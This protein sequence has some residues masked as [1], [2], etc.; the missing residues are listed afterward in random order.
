M[1]RFQWAQL[2]ALVINIVFLIMCLVRG[3]F[4]AFTCLS[5]LLVISFFLGDLVDSIP[6]S[7]G[8]VSTL[9]A[10]FVIGWLIAAVC[11][12]APDV[13]P[14]ATLIGVGIIAAAQ[15]MMGARIIKHKEQIFT[16][17]SHIWKI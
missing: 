8:R 3:M 4:M 9:G 5:Y 1:K 7:S 16:S 15:I 12:L 14:W 13:Y 2:P 10:L 17:S 11:F 6:T